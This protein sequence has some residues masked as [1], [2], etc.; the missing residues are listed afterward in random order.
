MEEKIIEGVIIGATGGS[1]AG[2]M[3]YLIQYLHQEIKDCCESKRIRNWLEENTSK[4][5][6][7]S[8]KTIASWTNLPLDR[9]QFLC[10]HDELVKLSTGE[11]EDM[12]ALRSKIS[13]ATFE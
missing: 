10:S 13:E 7:R 3:V 9:V 11:K 1:L 8:T 6:W 5:T 4:D 12:W 2:I